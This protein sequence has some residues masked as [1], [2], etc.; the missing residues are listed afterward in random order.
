MCGSDGSNDIQ[1][2]AIKKYVLTRIGV[3]AGTTRPLH[4]VVS[5]ARIRQ[6]FA[7]KRSLHGVNG[8]FSQIFNAIIVP[9][10][11]RAKVS[12]RYSRAPLPFAYDLFALCAFN[13]TQLI[14]QPY[15]GAGGTTL[16]RYAGMVI[17]RIIYDR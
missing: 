1:L 16:Y 9:R 2:S 4:G 15:D 17:L 5:G 8:H 10:S 6:K 3:S 13:R 12:L 7:K 14:I 11:N